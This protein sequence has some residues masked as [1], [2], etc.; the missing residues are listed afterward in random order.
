M[1]RRVIKPR[2]RDNEAGL[3]GGIGLNNASVHIVDEDGITVRKET[4][5]CRGDVLY[6]RE[7]WFADELFYYR[8]DSTPETDRM[9]KHCG[10]KWR[11]P[12]TMPREAARLFL[13]VKDVGVERL[14]DISNEG[15]KAEGVEGGM[16]TIFND[17]DGYE[18]V[19]VGITTPRQDFC[20]LWDTLN[21]KRGYSWQSNPWVWVYEF[22]R[23]E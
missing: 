21:A 2:Y 9:L 11:S 18:H 14:W 1:T 4:P 15:A 16:G 8:A 13:E 20:E 5:Y 19:A 17:F 6:V 22:G 3:E 7:T 23:V 10:Y 12:A